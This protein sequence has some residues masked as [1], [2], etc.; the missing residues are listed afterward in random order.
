MRARAHPEQTERLKTLYRYEILDTPRE[1][2]FDEIVALTAQICEAPISVINIIDAERQ[3]FKAEVGLG[4]RETPIDTSICAHI[5]LD[6]NFVEIEDTLQD[7]RLR[8]NPLCLAERGGLRFY[9]G[10]RLVA[11]NG[12]PLGTLCVLDHQPRQLNDLQRNAIRVL[13]RQVMKQFELRLA[14]RDQ[15]VLRGEIDHRV[16]NSLQTVSSIVRL[17]QRDVADETARDALVAVQRR[18]DAIGALHEQLQGSSSGQ[19]IDIRKFL[20]RLVGLLQETA[21]DNVKLRSSAVHA[22]VDSD[23][24]SALG[25]IVSEFVAN[26][27]KHGFPET[28]AGNVTVELK[29]ADAQ[30]VLTC[31]DDGLGSN[32][33]KPKLGKIGSLGT[34]IMNAAASRLNGEFSQ[35]LDENGSRLSMTF[36]HVYA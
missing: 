2:E 14:L 11:P 27:L 22:V 20:E 29:K 4:T 24:A 19:L 10:A 31:S 23:T 26:S 1:E 28:Q 6:E 36:E 9:A 18:I 7:P 13:A 15:E 5:I 25:M 17:Y 21:P 12:M 30:F 32:A 35:A 3:W 16:K 8:D 34:N 33:R